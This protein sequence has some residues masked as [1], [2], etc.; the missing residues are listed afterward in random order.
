[1]PLEQARLYLSVLNAFTITGYS[2]M[3]PEVTLEGSTWELAGMYSTNY[4]VP[5][6]IVGGIEIT[7]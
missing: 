2:G 4:P 1:M 6:T 7:F 3:D 5:R